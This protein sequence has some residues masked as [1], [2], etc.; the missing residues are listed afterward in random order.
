[1]GWRRTTSTTR[2]R[3]ASSGRLLP[4]PDHIFLISN[5]GADFL[6]TR[7]LKKPPRMLS[8]RERRLMPDSL[9]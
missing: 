5:C 7:W 2:D 4:G 6:P 9:S 1:M 3:S 8:R